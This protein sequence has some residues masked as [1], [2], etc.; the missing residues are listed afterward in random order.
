MLSDD[1]KK[2]VSE[3][4]FFFFFPLRFLT[5]LSVVSV[6]ITKMVGKWKNSINVFVV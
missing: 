2:C 5:K 4:F 3:D 6:Q 1:R